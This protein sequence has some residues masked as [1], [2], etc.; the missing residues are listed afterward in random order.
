MLICV[1]TGFASG[2]PFYVLTHLLPAWF[3]E[4]GIDLKTVGLFALTTLPYTWKFVWAPLLD[5]YGWAA[6]GRRRSWA[7]ASQLVLLV[8]IGGL[9]WLDPVDDLTL[10]AVFAGGIAFASATQDMAVDALRRELLRDAELGL[11][12]A[13][14]VNSYRIASMV[15]ASLAFIV[16]D[17][18]PWWAV[19]AVVA[20]F[21][22]VGLLT[23]AW[24][25]EPRVDRGPAR[26]G[27]RSMGEPVAAFVRAHGR[28]G[29]VV[30]LLFVLLYK[31]GDSMATAL[32]T[33]FYLSL[34]FSMTQIGT[35][36]Q[37]AALWASI[38]GGLLGGLLMLRVGIARAL[39][40][41]GLVQ[42]ISIF[43]FVALTRIG[44]HE[45]WLFAVVGFEYLGVGLGTSALVAYM[46]KITDRRYTATQ[47]A[48]L[49]SLTGL[50]RIAANASS[51]W[52]V[53]QLGWT[54][55]FVLCAAVATPG[56]ALLWW[57]APWSGGREG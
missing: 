57:V 8:L 6:L 52:L 39:W 37:G 56:M 49:T 7:G 40:I 20:A 11:G 53:E 16:A 36:A 35:V 29:T 31:L 10:I 30:V 44:P 5:W 1:G 50:P 43:G 26:E 19:H 4:R 54:G 13:L 48:L 47:L 55:F 41:F 45:G 25:V 28:W 32:A 51:G 2:L 3:T 18:A 34:G 9:G 24:A 42:W 27:W 46:A 12:N 14:F 38:G 33:P 15:P 21:M 23:T 17:R 22:G